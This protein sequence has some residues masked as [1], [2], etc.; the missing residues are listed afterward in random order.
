M[1]YLLECNNRDREKIPFEC[2]SDEE[3]ITLLEDGDALG[4]SVFSEDKLYGQSRTLE[5]PM[6]LVK[7]W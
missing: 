5:R 2:D 1:L 3:A 7:K 6:R 4:F